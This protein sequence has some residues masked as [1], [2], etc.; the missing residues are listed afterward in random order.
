MRNHNA[1]RLRAALPWAAGRFALLFL[2][3]G[4]WLLSFRALWA[5]PIGDGALLGGCAGLL[6]QTLRLRGAAAAQG[7]G[8]GGDTDAANPS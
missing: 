1:A 8:K 7:A 6:V 3:L 2:L 4:G 5:L